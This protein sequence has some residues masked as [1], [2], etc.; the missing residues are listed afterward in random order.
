MCGR[1]TIPT[2]RRMLERHFAAQ[3]SFEFTP[4]YNVAP[5]QQ[6]PIVRNANG[7]RELLLA[8]W[9][10]VPAWVRDPKGFKPSLINAR[11]ESAAEK[12]SFREAL[13]SRRCLIPAGGFYE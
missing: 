7:T 6:V 2:D 12:P 10:L 9:G 1:Y 3:G 8:R 11:A 4:R 13:K 5:T